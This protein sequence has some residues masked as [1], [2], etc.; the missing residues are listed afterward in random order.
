MDEGVAVPGFG[1]DA[2][3]GAVDLLAGHAGSHRLERG[4]VGGQHR[5]IGA[6]ELGGRLA[7]M[8]V[9]VTSEL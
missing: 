4:L 5:L 8:A 3:R 6:D 2:P 7:D 1:E 9:R